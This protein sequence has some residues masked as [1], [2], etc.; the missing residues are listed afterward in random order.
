MF[1]TREEK[2]GR[3]VGPQ[4]LETTHPAGPTRIHENNPLG[5]AGSSR[6]RFSSGLRNPANLGPLQ[7]TTSSGALPPNGGYEV[8]YGKPPAE[9][10]FR[11][12]QSGNPRGRPAGR[13]RVKDLIVDEIYR[14][15]QEGD[16]ERGKKLPAIQAVLR[17]QVKLALKGHGPAQRAVIK[18]AIDADESEA[19]IEPK[20]AEPQPQSAGN[21]SIPDA[22]RPED[23]AF[24]ECCRIA[25]EM[26]DEQHAQN[27]KPYE[28]YLQRKNNRRA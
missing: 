21:S 25:L 8:G 15:V 20:E 16:T 24:L 28:I 1:Q 7:G 13:K 12:G 9:T 22:E 18:L 19:E 6:P 3:P 26:T 27:E 5:L 2:R 4:R 23:Q 11:K 10:R 14:L 17:S